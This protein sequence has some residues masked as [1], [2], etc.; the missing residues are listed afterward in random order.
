MPLDF[1]HCNVKSPRHFQALAYLNLGTPAK[2][3]FAA[4]LAA[5]YEC[6]PEEHRPLVRRLMS[7][8]ALARS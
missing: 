7:L 1:S 2:E 4:Y 8:F 5:W 3:D 6:C